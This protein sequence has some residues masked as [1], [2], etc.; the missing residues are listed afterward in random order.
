LQSQ[1]L[2]QSGRRNYRVIWTRK[3]LR[4]II[5]MELEW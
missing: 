2:Y 1:C 5:S 3:V 4:R